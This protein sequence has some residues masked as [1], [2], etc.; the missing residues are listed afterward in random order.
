MGRHF[1]TQVKGWECCNVIY[2]SFFFFFEEEM[3]VKK[4]RL[5]DLNTEMLSLLIHTCTVPV[6]ACRSHTRH[7]RIMNNS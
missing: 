1:N 5:R 2:V 7:A 6:E 4:N 3:N